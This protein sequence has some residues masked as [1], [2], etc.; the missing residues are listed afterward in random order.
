[1]NKMVIP[2]E[3]RYDGAPNW[4]DRVLVIQE[5]GGKTVKRI[6]AADEAEARTIAAKLGVDP[7]TLKLEDNAALVAAGRIPQNLEATPNSGIRISKRL[8]RATL[9]MS[10][11]SNT[12]DLSADAEESSGRVNLDDLE[13]PDLR[14]LAQDHYELEFPQ[15]ATKAFMLKEIKKLMAGP[16]E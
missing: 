11:M 5:E 4:L 14:K 10:A 13:A 15:N 3:D 2:W 9:R 12:R 6:I 8:G 7:K 1:M 16:E